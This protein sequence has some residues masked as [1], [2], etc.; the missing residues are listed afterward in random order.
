MINQIIFLFIILFS[1]FLKGQIIH[2]KYTNV[3]S[4]IATVTE[5]LY[6][7]D[8]NVISRQDSLIQ[9]TKQT[10]VDGRAS[11]IQKNGKK[12]AYYFISKVS[13]KNSRDFFINDYL[14][15]GTEEYFIHDSV[16]KPIWSI[17]ESSTRKIAGYL[18]TKA[19]TNFRGSEIV[20]YFAKDLPYS[21]GPFK[22]FGLPGLILDVRVLNKSYDIWR[23]DKVD[24]NY[25]GNVNFTPSFKN[26]S[27]MEMKNFVQLK[28]KNY[29][30]ASNE[31]N[32]KLSTPGVQIVNSPTSRFSVEK[33]YEWEK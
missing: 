13:D 6:I 19:T 4:E 3:R 7:Q 26:H 29:Q 31:I 8:N 33:I 5:D 14:K 22:F 27:R 28:E 15:N 18:C 20:A 30:A 23:A 21:T 24:V 12:N 11:V 17:D 10:Y 16:E 9:F 32:K 2:V 25:S 1:F